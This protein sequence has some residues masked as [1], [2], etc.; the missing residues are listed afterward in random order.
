MRGGGLRVS[1]FESSWLALSSRREPRTPVGS[2]GRAA[3]CGRWRCRFQP[4]P[5]ARRSRGLR[6]NGRALPR[7]CP[8]PLSFPCPLPLSLGRLSAAP[9]Q[10]SI[11]CRALLPTSPRSSQRSPCNTQSWEKWE[12]FV[13][14]D[15]FCRKDCLS[16]GVFYCE[17]AFEKTSCAACLSTLA[18]PLCT[19]LH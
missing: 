8:L 14:Y 1:A 2:G 13:F 6:G 18:A 9:P 16:E 3:L 12:N 4:W 15:Y 10:R 11:G 17:I 5:P 7:P 19:L